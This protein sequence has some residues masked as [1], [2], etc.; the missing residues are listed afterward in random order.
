MVRTSKARKNYTQI[1][2]VKTNKITTVAGLIELLEEEKQIRQIHLVLQTQ[3]EDK[4]L[5]NT[6]TSS[7]ED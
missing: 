7:D 4:P 3:D 1:I 2:T 6:E 5:Y